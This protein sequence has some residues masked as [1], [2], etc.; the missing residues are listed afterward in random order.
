M[1]KQKSPCSDKLTALRKAMDEAGVDG[2]LIPR[3]DE[4]QGEFVAPYAERLKYISGFT[5]SGGIALV[6]KK[7][8]FVLS[9]GRYVLQLAQQVDN[10]MF[11]TGDYIK[12]PPQEW[13]TK[14]AKEGAVIG[15]DPWLHTPAQ[16]ARMEKAL[17][18]KNITLKPVDGN[19]VD[20][21][22]AD[23]P[24]KP[25]A[26]VM[27]F[28]D[29]I[30]G[31]SSV[32]KR[33]AIAAHIVEQGGYACVL[34]LPDSIAWL[35]NIRG[36]D[37]DYI[38]SVLS[39]AVIG[40]CGNVRWFVDPDK[41][42][43]NI[44]G[45]LGGDITLCAPDDM[46]LQFM[47]LA[48]EAAAEGLPVLFDPAHT[49]LRIKTLLEERGAKLK[50]APDPV[51]APKALKTKAERDA[52]RKTHIADGVALVK[53]L[54][55]LEQ[56]ATS[57][58][59]SELTATQKL[60]EFRAQSPAF[61]GDSFPTIAGF[62]EN[63]A[64]VHYRASAETD[65]PIVAGN[66]LLVDSG[67]QYALDDIYG[68][69]DI[70]RTVAIGQ[71]RDDLRADICTNFTRVLK[72]HIA[73]AQAKFPKG[74]VGSQIDI[75][76]RKPLWDAGLDYA[77]GTGHGVGC[78]L[79]VHEDAANIP[80]RGQTPFEAG[81]LISNEPGY[82][83]EGAY[84][85]RTENLVLVVEDEGMLSFETVSFAPIDRSLI[86]TDMLTKSER[87]WLNTYHKQVFENLAPLLDADTQSWLE[88][89]TK[90]V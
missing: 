74:T 86:V 43:D 82:Y 44:R 57:G 62:G 16:L 18:A 67:G 77:H 37:I 40:R 24:S 76:A 70:T 90:A 61:K 21:I 52:I 56:E 84:G 60:R 7:K 9:D 68:T 73:L 30:A 41:I 34:S 25:N 49:P 6:L 54:K 1:A 50:E 78:Y 80:S 32:E 33:Q 79:A 5:G 17:M 69:T 81:M 87:N 22:W 14:H 35:L 28:P 71:P 83:H 27:I 19:L 4:Y 47:A 51:I 64:I 88:Q 20:A 8:A 66:L 53:F 45:V 29:E 58:Q 63:G 3:A 38:P 23:Q 59:E 11:E 12:T 46:G 75:L 13:I 31:Q 2:Y 26:P 65:T 36:S 15:Y 10:D 39:Y 89:K 55:W 42:G 72:G 85:I 48:Q